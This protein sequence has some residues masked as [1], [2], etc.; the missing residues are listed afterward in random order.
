[1]GLWKWNFKRTFYIAQHFFHDLPPQIVL[2]RTSPLIDV[3]DHLELV[4]VGVV[5]LGLR[6]RVLGLEARDVRVLL[7]RQKRRRCIDGVEVQ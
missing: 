4:G 5:E 6:V 1:M 2:H 3:P 7:G